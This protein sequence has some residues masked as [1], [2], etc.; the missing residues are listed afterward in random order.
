[1]VGLNV[2]DGND[3]TTGIVGYKNNDPRFK[4]DTEGNFFVGSGWGAIESGSGGGLK[5]DAEKKQLSISGNVKMT[6]GST[7]GNKSAEEL[8]QDVGDKASIHDMNSAIEQKAD[9]ILSTVSNTYTDKNT[10][11]SMQSS[12][13]QQANL[14]SQKVS[15]GD[16]N[17]YKTQTASLIA[18]KVTSSG[19]SSQIQQDSSSI[20]IGFNK[21]NNSFEITPS[22]VNL[23][24]TDGKKHMA[25]AYGAMRLY[26]PDTSAEVGR[27]AMSAWKGTNNYGLHTALSSGT[28][29]AVSKLSGSEYL[30]RFFINH[31]GV[32]GKDEGIHQGTHMFANNWRYKNPRLEW[33]DGAANGDIEGAGVYH[34]YG[35]LSEASQLVVYVED[36]DNDNVAFCT[37]RGTSINTNLNV[38][39]G[40]I[41]AWRDLHMNGYGIRGAG[42]FSASDYLIEDKSTFFSANN[43]T[44]SLTQT[45]SKNVEWLGRGEIIKGV[46]EITLPEG[47]AFTSYSVFPIAL[48]RNSIYVMQKNDNKFIVE[49]DKDCEF[50]F[51]VKFKNDIDFYSTQDLRKER[52]VIKDGGK[53]EGTVFSSKVSED[54]Q[55]EVK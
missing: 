18:T 14:I 9:S 43:L 47:L 45:I 54:A 1:A 31:G 27:Y 34:Y 33:I 26:N 30:A 21:I 19:V 7:I 8:L 2:L 6:S 25:L 17:T 29:Y 50:E 46:C 42:T 5:Y 51:I 22:S 23:R 44:K 52:P 39:R 37:K 40:G 20:R 49:A 48:G 15:S 28:Y 12:I 3:K 36:D 24:N 11:K 32:P 35:G 4:L 55:T 13:N 10:T 41:K 38:G 53:K 16:F